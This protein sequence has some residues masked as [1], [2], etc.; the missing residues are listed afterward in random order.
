MRPLHALLA[1]FALLGLAAAG[2]ATPPA[3]APAA[4]KVDW[5]RVVARVP[6]G[7]VRQGNPNAPVKLVEYGSRSC[8]TCGRFAQEGVGPLRA[9]YI[10]TGKVSYEFRDYPVHPQDP[11][12]AILGRCTTDAGFFPV[13]DAFY[14]EQQRLNANAES[15]T[16]AE[17]APLADAPLT[18]VQAFWA[19][20]A[21]YIDLL[22]RKGMS[23]ARIQACLNDPA[24]IRS[25]GTLIE[26]ARSQGVNSTPTFFVNGNRL[27]GIYL[28][29]QLEPVL[30]GYGG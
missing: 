14:A 23:A 24:N 13:L 26:T 3:A 20:K 28:W 25:F 19:R 17:L 4:Q 11:A 9:N 27:D 22:Q 1:P 2:P 15:A 29:A 5:V 8:P 30:K 12:G 6:G 10:A 16:D 18:R 7:G 21:G